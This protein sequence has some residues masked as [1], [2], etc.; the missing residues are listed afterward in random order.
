MQTSVS[1]IH[2]YPL[3]PPGFQ[4]PLFPCRKTKR[5]VAEHLA[6]S[7]WLGKASGLAGGDGTSAH[8]FEEPALLVRGEDGGVYVVRRC[9]R[10]RSARRRR[11]VRVLER[12]REISRWWEPERGVDR[13]S[14]RLLL[15]GGAVVDV[16]LERETGRWLWVGTMD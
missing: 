8:V 9:R 13:L 10:D 14:L 15:S 3:R 2:R 6:R 12:W 5:A 4:E 16:A 7:D 1:E 11:V